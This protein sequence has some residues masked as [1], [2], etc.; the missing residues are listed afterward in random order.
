[1]AGRLTSDHRAANGRLRTAVGGGA[2]RTP[3]PDFDVAAAD[4]WTHD[5]DAKTRRLV[6][7]RAAKVPVYRF[8]ADGEAGLLEA[9][10]DRLLPQD[11]RPPVERVPIAP[12]IDDRLA[13]NDG[14]GYRYDDMP[15]D[16][17]AV[18]RGLQAIDRVSQAVHGRPFVGLD[19][20]AQDAILRLAAEGKDAGGVWERLPPKRWFQL[21]LNQVL[22]FYYSHPTAWSE[23]G[24]NGPSSPRGHM[25]LDLERR[26]PWEAVERRPRSSAEIVR[27]NVGRGGGESG[28]ATH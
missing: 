4:K 6:G 28:E 21:V 5:W 3:Y 19:P 10:C 25:R 16:Q 23:I 1:M 9:V 24:F 12:W 11:D 7:A 2:A 27:R 13:R 15:S 22:S 8:L 14:D 20:S 18:R 17:E 26:D